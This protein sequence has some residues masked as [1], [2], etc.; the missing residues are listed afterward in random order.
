MNGQFSWTDSGLKLLT[1]IRTEI[2]NSGGRIALMKSIMEENR[3]FFTHKDWVHLNICI[4]KHNYIKRKRELLLKSDTR[5]TKEDIDYC[6]EKYGFIKTR[7]LASILNRSVHAVQNCFRSKA[8]AEQKLNV[9]MNGIYSGRLGNFNGKNL[10]I[11]N[12]DTHINIIKDENDI[13]RSLYKV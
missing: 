12:Q 9:K 11:H 1:T 6:L 8:T 3:D 5:W 10:T 7:R 2:N 13:K 4:S